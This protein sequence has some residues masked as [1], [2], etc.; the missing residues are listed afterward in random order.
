MRVFRASFS[1]IFHR[2]IGLGTGHR[3]INHFT[4]WD[5]NAY[6]YYWVY[7]NC[8]IREWAREANK[9]KKIS[10]EGGEV[11]FKRG[12]IPIYIA[13]ENADGDSI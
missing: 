13:R 5:L 2:R 7:C 1:T 12:L 6:Y 11:Q 8:I 4:Q 3:E 9:K 10:L